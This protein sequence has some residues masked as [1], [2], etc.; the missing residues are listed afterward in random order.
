[1]TDLLNSDTAAVV[2]PYAEA[3]EKEQSLRAHA[4]Q[5]RG[6]VI[7]LDQSRLATASLAEAIDA[8]LAQRT[9]LAVNLNGATNSATMITQWLQNSEA[10]R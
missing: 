4:L 8:A 1:M 5:A 9:E 3:D 7:A 10:M 2:I 6:R